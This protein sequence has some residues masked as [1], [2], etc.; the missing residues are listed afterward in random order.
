MS[1]PRLP[2]WPVGDPLDPRDLP[3]LPAGRVQCTSMAANLPRPSVAPPDR[4]CTRCYWWPPDYAEL[5]RRGHG[6]ALEAI[7]VG[8]RDTREDREGKMRVCGGAV[9]NGVCDKCKARD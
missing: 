5:D 2:W 1:D 8:T 3:H 9:R 6:G 4:I 7:D